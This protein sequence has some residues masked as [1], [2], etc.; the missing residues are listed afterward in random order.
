M[1][2]IK[3]IDEIKGILLICMLIYH[4]VL[5]YHICLGES[6][7]IYHNLSWI[8]F[9]KAIAYSFF[10]ISGFNLAYLFEKNSSYLDFLKK[11]KI[12]FISAF[13]VSLVSYIIYDGEKFIVFGIL[14]SILLG[15]ILA[16]PLIC[17]RYLNLL[18]ALA[19]FI[20]SNYESDFFNGVLYWT[21][22]GSSS[23]KDF[24]FQPIFPNHAF[25]FLGVFISESIKFDLRSDHKNSI[26]ISKI[27]I[28]FGRQSLLFYMAHVP[29]IAVIIYLI[30]HAI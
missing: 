7:K 13:T 23:I 27:M 5:F 1:T 9:Q 20:I 22:L 17:Y 21:G 6:N 4:A 14:H 11:Q 25:I 2:K 16:R 10:F 29:L 28:Y 24:D 12:L 15:R 26:N 30:C 18:I 19:I 8:I 3:V